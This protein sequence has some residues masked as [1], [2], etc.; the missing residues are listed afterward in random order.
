[1][2]AVLNRSFNLDEPS[3]DV[4]FSDVS[5]GAVFEDAIGSIAEEGITTGY[6]EDNTFRPN[7]DTT[8]AQFSVFLS[9]VLN[10]KEF[11][12]DEK[13]EGV[14][15]PAVNLD[16]HFLDVGQGDS[17]LLEPNGGGGNILIDGN[18]RGTDTEIVQY[19]EK[20]DINQLEWVVATHPDADHISGL[21]QVMEETD[22]E[23]V[24]GSGKEHTTDT[25]DEYMDTIDEQDINYVEASEGEYLDTAAAE[26]QIVSDKEESSDL[27]ESS[28]ALHL[29]YG[30]T[31]ALFTGDATK[32][33]EAEMIEEY[34]V[35]ADVLKVGHHGADTSTS[36]EFVEE[37]DPDMAVLSYGENSYGHP[38]ADVVERLRNQGSDLYS[39][40]EAGHIEISLSHH[41]P[42]AQMESWNGD[43]QDD[44]T[45]EINEPVE[46]EPASSYP[47]NINTA[48]ND[49]LQE[50]TGVGPAIA[51][52]II[53]Y[54]EANGSFQSIEE[55]MNVGGIAEGRFAEMEDEITM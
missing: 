54:R 7:N 12:G 48:G 4:T 40:D 5:E 23:N 31:T 10:E 20:N 36:E 9:R 3:S 29:T 45:E 37:V 22:V 38:D 49:T 33:Q 2:A 53:E 52:N 47:I 15:Y 35:E 46:D 6:E 24:L 17:I 13:D 27:N 18:D 26:V 32:E 25:Y 16:L 51:E 42:I 14:A 44:E 30:E 34:D 1:M 50:I 41:R 21:M 39:T 28:V 55:I 43:G 8:R 19:L 11:V